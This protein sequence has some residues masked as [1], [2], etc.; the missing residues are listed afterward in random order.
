MQ[1]YPGIPKLVNGANSK[2]NSMTDKEKHIAFIKSNGTFQID[3]K[4]IIFNM[5]EIEI[6]KKHGHWFK[7]LCNGTLK[8]ITDLQ[9][10]FVMVSKGEGEPFSLEEKAWFKYLGRKKV[11]AKYGDSLDRVYY[12]EEDTFYNRDM[13]KRLRGMMYNEMH[14]NHR[15]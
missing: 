2:H 13:V 10:R 7:A 5:N 12:P 1:E 11:E 6:L 4:T 3:C 9:N 15:S 14:K 8:P